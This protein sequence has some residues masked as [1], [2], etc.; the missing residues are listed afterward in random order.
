MAC[1]DETIA[2]TDADLVNLARLAVRSAKECSGSCGDR[3]LVD[4]DALGDGLTDFAAG[5][6]ARPSLGFRVVIEGPAAAFSA[7]NDAHIEA[8]A[9]T[10]PPRPP[11]ADLI[12]YL[13]SGARDDGGNVGSRDDDEASR[14]FCSD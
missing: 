4:E 6:V 14:V 11:R 9:A 1:E 12:S 13:I 2:G 5:F 7:V 10:L 3:G 8:T